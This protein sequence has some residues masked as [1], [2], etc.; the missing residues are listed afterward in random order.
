MQQKHLQLKKFQKATS[1]M[2]QTTAMETMK[3]MKQMKQMEIV[4]GWKT[5]LAQKPQMEMVKG[6]IATILTLLQVM[7]ARTPMALMRQSSGHLQDDLP[8]GLPC[9]PTRTTIT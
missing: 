5:H 6:W 4:T 3:Q 9:G 2:K 1:Q 8:G 7:A